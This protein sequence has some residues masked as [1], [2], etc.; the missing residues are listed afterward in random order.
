MPT[1][2]KPG[3]YPT[4]AESV[5]EWLDAIQMPELKLVLAN[6]NITSPQQLRNL[7]PNDID[8][9]NLRVPGHRRKLENALRALVGPKPPPSDQLPSSSTTPKFNSTSS[10]YIDATIDKPRV[11][12][13]L[14]GVSV[15]LCDLIASGMR[16]QAKQRARGLRPHIMFDVGNSRPLLGRTPPSEVD[17]HFI[18][19]LLHTIF[20]QVRFSGYVPITMLMYIERLCECT[21][22]AL[23][24]RNWQPILLAAIVVAQKV[25]DDNYL[26]NADFSTV[27]ESYS[28]HE[29]NI[30]ELK[31]VEKLDYN[32][33]I[34]SSAFAARYFQLRAC[35]EL[36]NEQLC[37]RT[38]LDE[39][40]AR[41]MSARTASCAE[42]MQ[43]E[44]RS[45]STSPGRRRPKS[46][47][48]LA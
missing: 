19:R 24:K 10:L 18:Y 35:F 20:K 12:Q 36:E 28:N 22:H 21:G 14:F 16:A 43:R 26:C 13:Q 4:Q 45:K 42:K 44:A 3:D 27:S 23:C 32:L 1:L 46:K 30:L 31:F 39:D 8:N 2:V 6:A 11:D 40:E 41:R 5:D 25:S 29:L 17:E 7:T 15:A 47:A 38:P 34:S 48:V 33:Y 37:T 9:L